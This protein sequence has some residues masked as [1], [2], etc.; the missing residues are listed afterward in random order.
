LNS[1]ER[2]ETRNKTKRKRIKEETNIEEGLTR[3]ES[4]TGPGVSP[5][6]AQATIPL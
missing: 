4:I 2:I 3:P 5:A 1:N 6:L